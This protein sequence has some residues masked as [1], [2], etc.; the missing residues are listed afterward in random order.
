MSIT[1]TSTL[2]RWSTPLMAAVG[3]RSA[4]ARLMPVGVVWAV[5]ATGASVWTQ[6]TP[7]SASTSAAVSAVMVAE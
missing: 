1:A 7:G 5:V 3:L 6:S 2:T 4:S